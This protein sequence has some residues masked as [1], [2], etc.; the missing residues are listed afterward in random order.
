[1][2]TALSGESCCRRILVDTTYLGEE[3]ARHDAE[4]S[5]VWLY[6][7]QV[8]CWD[9]AQQWQQSCFCRASRWAR[10]PS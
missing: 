7:G 2:T 1:M 9:G 6:N 8:C 4:D 5:H 10:S 3:C